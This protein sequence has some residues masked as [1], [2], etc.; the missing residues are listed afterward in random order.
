MDID[1]LIAD[2]ESDSYVDR[3]KLADESL[4]QANLHSKWLDRL[5]RYRIKGF[6]FEKNI[7]DLRAILTEYYNGR[8]SKDELSEI[9]RD[10][11]RG[12]T[13]LKS[14]LE[15]LIEH[16]KDMVDLMQKVYYYKIMED[17]CT[18]VLGAIRDRG[19]SIKTAVDFIR[20]TDGN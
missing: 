17:Y 8:L 11:Y 4:R 7:L 12:K 2:W 16:D 19:F 3:A 18:S 13:P 9:G 5:T 14:E 10:Q 1:A 20:F 6:K 15:K